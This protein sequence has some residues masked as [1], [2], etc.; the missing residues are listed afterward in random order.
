MAEPGPGAVE[1]APCVA[2]HSDPDTLRAGFEFYRAFP[3]DAEDNQAKTATPL[4][5]PVLALNGALIAEPWVLETMR[6]L[7]ADA[8]GGVV[9]GSGHWISEEQPEAMV[10]RLIA[11]FAEVEG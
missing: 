8:Q 10:E 5:M 3:Q 9:E 4:P 2:A 1:L 11:F 7:A 6:P